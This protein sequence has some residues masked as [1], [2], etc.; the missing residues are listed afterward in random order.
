MF[1]DVYAILDAFIDLRPVLLEPICIRMVLDLEL[2]F[3]GPQSNF[4]ERQNLGR[5]KHPMPKTLNLTLTR[6]VLK[7]GLAGVIHTDTIL[8]SI[9]DSEAAHSLV[10]HRRQ[11]GRE[12]QLRGALR[13]KQRV[14]WRRRVCADVPDLRA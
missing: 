8:P 13:E 6:L 7:N 3:F 2:M 12:H 11:P 14:A 9:H 1:F 5:P 4:A 10:R